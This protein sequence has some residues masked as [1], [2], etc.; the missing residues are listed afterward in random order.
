MATWPPGLALEDVLFRTF[1]AQTISEMIDW[2]VEELGLERVNQTLTKAAGGKPT[3]IDEIR[4]GFRILGEYSPDARALLGAA[5]RTRKQGWFK[6]ISKVEAIAR[7]FLGP[8]W[9]TS[10]VFKALIDHLWQAPG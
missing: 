1:P 3:T 8:R 4:E 5:A 9:D 7:Q 2:A 6:S 10:P